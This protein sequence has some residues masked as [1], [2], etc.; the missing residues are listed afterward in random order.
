[1][2]RKSTRKAEGDRGEA[3]LE[4][5]ARVVKQLPIGV[6][7]FRATGQAV[8]FNDMFRRIH[9]I[10]DGPLPEGSFIDMIEQGTF[11]DWKVDPRMHFQRLMLAV[12]EGRSLSTQ[13]EMAD[14]V[15][16]VT[17]IPFG[18]DY[19]L[20]T[21]QDIT[22]K[23]RAEQ[24][25]AF[26]ANHDALTGLPNRAAFTQRLD[27]ALETAKAQNRKFALISLDLDR[28]KDV[29]D[30]FGHATGDA[31]LC[32]VAERFRAAADRNF[33]ARLGGDEFTLISNEGHQPERGSALAQRL[34]DEVS[35]EVTVEGRDLLVG[36]SIGIAVYPD[37]GEDA[38]TLLKSADAALYRAKADGRG[39][40]RHF[41]PAMDTLIHDKRLLQQDLRLAIA[42]NEFELTYQPQATIDG[43]IQGFEALLR[44]EHPTRG[45]VMPDRFINLAEE[46]GLIVPIGEWVLR[47]A[48]R[49]AASW[50]N[51]LRVAVN[52]SPIQF[53]YGDL[54]KTIHEI[55]IESGLAPERLEIEVTE[56]VLVDNFGRALN[57]LRRI[58]ALGCRVAM[59]DFGTG[60]SSLSYLQAF[61]FDKLKIDHSF[62][63]KL[64]RSEHAKEIVRAVIGLGRGLNL[65][66]VAEGVETREQ[67]DFLSREHCAGIQGYLIGRPGP[68]TTYSEVLGG[69]VGGQPVTRVPVDRR[70][71]DKG[72]LDIER[73]ETIEAPAET[74][75]AERS[76]SGKSGRGRP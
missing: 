21:Q 2:S 47:Q 40:V 13:V 32:E 75:G 42:R 9:H 56:G 52:V 50:T 62:I 24:K 12:R 26:L 59:D 44:W 35:G 37:D 33:L 20:S 49:E 48:C 10:P 15:V 17:D 7:L 45:T 29:N 71:H 60:Y 39:L 23:V 6:G 53:R 5:L 69:L 1:M 57:L 63:Q 43:D 46:N 31:L 18:D 4:T 34:F 70:R 58:K 36:L 64:P 65:P 74:P 41:E 19:I 16:E 72:P 30:V 25:I 61:P 28:F 73:R 8:F 55:L 51:P 38:S 22:G 76:Q 3:D 66:I 68:I 11:D 67:L 14:R 27:S 54:A